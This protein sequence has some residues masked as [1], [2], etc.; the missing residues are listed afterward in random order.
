MSQGILLTQ[1]SGIL[2][3]IAALLG[4]LMNLIV[5]G[6][7]VITGNG[8]NPSLGLAIILFTIVIYLIMTPLTYKQQKFSKLS[9]KMNPEIQAVQKK[10][11][12]KKDN[13]SV[14]AMNAETKEIYAKYGVSPTGSCVQLLIQM[15][16]L[17]SLYRV[18]YN[19]P[20]YVGQVKDTFHPLV[21]HV[22]G[23]E[24]VIEF[25]KNLD[26]SRAYS[27][28]FDADKFV[29]GTEAYTNTLIDCFNKMSTSSWNTFIDQFKDYADDARNTME[30]LLSYNDFL[31][32]NIGNAPWEVL[33]SNFSAGTLTAGV[34]I[35]AVIIPLLS[36]L[37]QWI[38]VKLMPQVSKS[39]DGGTADSVAASMKTMNY[40]MPLMSAFFCFTLPA[41]MG[42]YWI[43]GAI[44][45][46]IQQVIINKHID[47]ID[48][49]ALIEKNKEKYEEKAKKNGV[50]KEQMNSYAS[51]NTK[52]MN[53]SKSLFTAEEKEEAISKAN[54]FYSNPE[55]LKEGSIAAR[56]NLVRAYNEKNNKQ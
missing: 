8:K 39:G 21:D 46:S 25:V 53:S 55:N 51:M 3:P 24:K 23:N 1:T 48:L 18:I 11:K 31:G 14:M 29:V 30:S 38:N 22:A 4:N 40:I 32:I 56:A 16:I 17:F 35:G 9:A 42:I 5:Q 15:P 20:A 34:V 13:A 43:A 47:K 36:A 7:D 41:G 10:Y 52:R 2:Q 19:I 27:S 44:V 26:T 37:T 28:Q 6:L 49:D 33:T 45:R 54:E 50:S 12:G